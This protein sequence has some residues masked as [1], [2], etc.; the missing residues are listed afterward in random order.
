MRHNTWL[1]IP[2]TLSVLVL[3][4]CG[5]QPTQSTNDLTLETASIS[6]TWIMRRPKPTERK[7]EV[8]AVVPNDA[9]QSILYLI[10]GS[11]PFGKSLATVE[12]YNPATDRWSRKQDMPIALSGS[13][14]AGVIGGK[15]YV[16]GGHKR[17]AWGPTVYLLFVYDPA[18]NTWTQKRG[19]P[20]HGAEGVA[21]VIGD[22]LYVAMPDPDRAGHTYFFRYNPATNKWTTLPS[23][24]D[25]YGMGAVLYGKFYLFGTQTEAYDPA[26]NAWTRKA[27]QP[28]IP[29]PGVSAGGAAAA[30]AGKLYV[31]DEN[32]FVYDPLSDSWTVRTTG[33][34]GVPGV[35]ARVFVDGKPR[36]EVLQDGTDNWQYFP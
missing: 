26:T 4:S 6:D 34:R 2:A 36:I 28:P 1:F 11:E 27:P 15:I 25:R 8:A 10:G 24:G 19:M 32:T 23:P 5:D 35:A 14:G 22:Q 21:G 3:T 12:A 29:D 20:V 18:R 13:N 33:A 31:F 16:A 9:G 30:A 17:V 7:D